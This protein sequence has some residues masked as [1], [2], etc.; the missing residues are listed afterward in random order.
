MKMRYTKRLES[1]TK[2][3]KKGSEEVPGETRY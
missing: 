2:L 3:L 1:F